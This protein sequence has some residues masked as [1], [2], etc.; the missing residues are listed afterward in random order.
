MGMKLELEIGKYKRAVEKVENQL[1][2]KGGLLSL[3]NYFTNN[4]NLLIKQCHQLI[5]MCD[6]HTKLPTDNDFKKLRYY[7]EELENQWE[8]INSFKSKT[9]QFASRY[10][11]SHTVMGC[12][13]RVSKV[14]FSTEEIA[15]AQI[16]H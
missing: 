4:F 5:N 1:M 14:G 8:Q 10:A 9:N 13:S 12:D 3:K 11:S 7:G 15:L 6:N 2:T 16:Q